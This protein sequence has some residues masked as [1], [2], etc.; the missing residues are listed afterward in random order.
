MIEE[1]RHSNLVSWR[2]VVASSVFVI[3]V[4]AVIWIFVGRAQQQII[5]FQASELAEVVARQAASSRTVYTKHVVSK[6]SRDGFGADL[7]SKHHKGYVPLPAQFLKLLAQ[8]S[9]QNSSGLYQYRPLSKWNLNQDQGLKDEFQR[10]AWAQLEQQDQ[11]ALAKPSDWRSV[12]RVEIVD[13][14]RTLRYLRPDLAASEACVSCHNRL[15]KTPEIIARRIENGV[16]PGKQWQLNQ[17]MGAIEVQVPLEKIEAVAQNQKHTTLSLI[18]AVIVAGLCVIGLFVLVDVSRSR[19]MAKQLSHQ[20]NHD[21][22]TGLFNR[23]MFERHLDKLFKSAHEQNSEHALLFMDLDQFKVVNDTCGHMAGDELLR[24]LATL[25]LRDFRSNDVFARIGGDEFGVLLE[26]CPMN[27][28]AEIADRIRNTVHEFRFAWDN[29]TFEIGVSIGLVAINAQS[30]SA[31]AVLSAADVACYLAKD[32]GRNRVYV[33]SLTDT[34]LVQRKSEMEWVS[35]IN[36]AMEEDR[37]QLAVQEAVALNDE[38]TPQHYQEVLLRMVDIDGN[39]VSTATVVNAAERYHF[40]PTVDRWVVKTTLACIEAGRLKADENNVVAINLSMM[41]INDDTFLDFIQ[42]QFDLHPKASPKHLCFEITETAAVR[43]LSNA[44]RF[45]GAVQK[46]GCRFALDDFGSGLSSFGYLK[47]IPVDFLKIDGGFVKDIVDDPIDCA[48][49][50]SIVHIARA[51]NLP[52]I[53]EWV[54]DEAVLERVKSLG[55][56]YAQGYG[57]SRPRSINIDEL[58]SPI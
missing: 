11:M 52:T 7:N 6:L 57:V 49:V 15:E 40:M 33:H 16:K 9:N 38:L 31:A 47:N 22:L 51:M 29:E 26:R 23:T 18:V 17:L 12:F 53:A 43:N 19:R 50:E 27:A 5:E 45:I 55:V 14:E 35:R 41:S 3:V 25:L 30:E 36:R 58:K 2:L 44:L 13:G 56:H 28:A 4:A 34:E 1:H 24:Q 42:E 10:W 37:L 21:S 54:E 32:E 46:F 20:A 8:E 48:M 39:T